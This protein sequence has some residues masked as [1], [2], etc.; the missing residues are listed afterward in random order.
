M[1][2]SKYLPFWGKPTDCCA[3]KKTVIDGFEGTEKQCQIKS[4]GPVVLFYKVVK[5]EHN[6]FI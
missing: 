3:K 6:V 1:S 5:R 2:M 4:V